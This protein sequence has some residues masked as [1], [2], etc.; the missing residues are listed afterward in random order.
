M[1]QHEP[2]K[3]CAVYKMTDPEV[4]TGCFHLCKMSTIGK[5]IGTKICGCTGLGLRAGEND[6][7]SLM[8]AGLSSGGDGDIC[9]KVDSDN[10]F[11]AYTLNGWIVYVG[12]IS[13]L[14]FLKKGSSVGENAQRLVV[15]PFT[16]NGHSYFTRRKNTPVWGVGCSILTYLHKRSESMCPHKDLQPYL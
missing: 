13:Q 16:A 4:H 9:S 1:L 10:G 3:Q 15:L 8:D 12:I 2:W 6:G 14:F 7:W 5:P 11:S